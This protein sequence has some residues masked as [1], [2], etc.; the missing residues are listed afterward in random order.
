MAIRVRRKVVMS[1][2]CP[3][4]GRLLANRYSK[5][6]KRRMA[7]AR[8]E[9]QPFV[10]ITLTYD[11]EPYGGTYDPD[12]P[13]RLWDAS[14]K[15]Q[16][17]ALFFRRLQRL[18]GLDL[19]GK[20]VRKAEFQR[21]GW[22]HFH[23]IVIGFKRI[24]ANLLREAWGHGRVHIA[25]GRRQHGEYIAKYQS[26]AGIGYPA[27]LYDRLGKSVKI[28]GCSRGFWRPIEDRDSVPMRQSQRDIASAPFADLEKAYGIERTIGERIDEARSTLV[29]RSDCGRSV[30]LPDLDLGSFLYALRV[31][32]SPCLGSQWGWLE[33]D[34]TLDQ[35][36]A[37][38]RFARAK[39]RAAVKGAA[40][41][42][43]AD[44]RLSLFN[45]QETDSDDSSEP[46]L[47]L[48]GSS[49]WPDEF[50]PF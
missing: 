5:R 49:T 9:K 50:A 11:R 13:E 43:P 14:I 37:A 22:L 46:V 12:G 28:W 44:A 20:W 40:L 17:V 48:V 31:T 18:T 24:D 7:F 4:G 32:G 33:Y 6:L 19:S 42:A 45:Q 38:A 39:Y 36:E 29:V 16:H 34:T 35:A 30:E 3:E 41:A 21:G 8:L 25:A 15:E 1:H 47:E 2:L 26:K 27:F 23:A 10:F